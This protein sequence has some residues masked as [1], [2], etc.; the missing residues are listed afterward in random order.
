M[1]VLDADADKFEGKPFCAVEATTILAE[2]AK[3]AGAGVLFSFGIVLLSK[4]YE[5]ILIAA[6]AQLPGL[7]ADVSIPALPESIRGAKEWLSTHL[8]EGYSSVAHQNEL[9]KAVSD[10]RPVRATHRSFR[11]FE[12]ALL[13]LVEAIRTEK[14]VV[15]PSSIADNLPAVK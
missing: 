1:A 14:H 9:T 15:T 11:R 8:P 7:A 5:S 10:W 12:N 4:E 6:A 13:Q 3:E 2:R